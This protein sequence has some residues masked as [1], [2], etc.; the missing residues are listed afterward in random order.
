MQCGWTRWFRANRLFSLT[1]CNSR[2]GKS[3]SS[4]MI[5][6]K[7]CAKY[8][9]FHSEHFTTGICR[10]I[11]LEKEASCLHSHHRFSTA[12]TPVPTKTVKQPL[13]LNNSK[14]LES[15]ALGDCRLGENRVFLFIN[16]LITLSI[17]HTNEV[18]L[19][20]FGTLVR[21]TVVQHWYKP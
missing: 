15:R 3:S 21:N 16:I 19:D 20:I 12:H 1:W 4:A 8:G 10:M 2:P 9:T 14:Q 6:R 11:Y 5:S 13:G 17:I 7:N 18:G